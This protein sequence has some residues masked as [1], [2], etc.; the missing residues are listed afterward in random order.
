MQI[1]YSV[2]HWLHTWAILQ[3]PNLQ[4]TIVAV[5]HQFTQVAKD[6]FSPKHKGGGLV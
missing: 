3:K 6:F 4:D 1:I 2:T 5:S